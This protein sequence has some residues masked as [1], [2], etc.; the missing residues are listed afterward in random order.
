MY[1]VRPGDSEAWGTQLFSVDGDTEAPSIAANWIRPEQCHLVTEV[2]FR[3]NSML[4]L[5]NSVGAHGANIPEDAT[6]PDLERYMY[7][8]RISPSGSAIRK[9]MSLLPEERRSK[10]SG[11]VKD[12]LA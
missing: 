1:V 12:Y 4:V 11:K 5:L 2:P 8:F 7:Q 3:R 10:W 9:M 6:P